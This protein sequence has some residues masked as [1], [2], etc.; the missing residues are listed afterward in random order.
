LIEPLM[1]W[2]MARHGK[3]TG[4]LLGTL[5]RVGSTRRILNFLDEKGMPI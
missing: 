2:A 1:L 4:S 5:F 3:L